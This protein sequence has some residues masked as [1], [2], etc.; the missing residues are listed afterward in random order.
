MDRVTASR[1][2]A[3]VINVHSVGDRADFAFVNDPV[4][5]PADAIDGDKAVPCVDER[6]APCPTS[7][8]VGH[9]T[10]NAIH[11]RHFTKRRSAERVHGEWREF[12][13]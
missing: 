12:G 4:H 8:V 3:K 7:V 6:A 1:V 13:E 2:S 10:Q 11:G 5:K 9:A